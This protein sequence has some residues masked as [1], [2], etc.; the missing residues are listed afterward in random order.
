MLTGERK[1]MMTEPFSGV[2][3]TILFHLLVFHL[4]QFNPMFLSLNFGMTLPTP[5]NQPLAKLVLKKN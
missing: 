3:M 2:K 1:K 5:A 4:L